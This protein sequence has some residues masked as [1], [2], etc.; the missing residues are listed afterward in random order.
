M[1]SETQDNSAFRLKLILKYS[2][3]HVAVNKGES[4][5]YVL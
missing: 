5:S 4:K 3:V 1:A 2:N